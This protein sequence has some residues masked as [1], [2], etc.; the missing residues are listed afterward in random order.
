MYPDK[1]AFIDND[2]TMSYDIVCTGNS[3]LYS[4]FS[5]L[6]LWKD[7]GYTSTVCASAKQTPQE[8]AHLMESVFKTQKPALVIIET[9]MLYDCSVKSE[10]KKRKKMMSFLTG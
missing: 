3:D 1:T 6:D 8:S 10:M 2:V 9:D 5:P 7:Y 4:A